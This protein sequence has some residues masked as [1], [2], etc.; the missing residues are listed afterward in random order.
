MFKMTFFVSSTVYQV[1]LWTKY[2]KGTSTS[3]NLSSGSLI[4]AVAVVVP[5]KSA[6]QICVTKKKEKKNDKI[7]WFLTHLQLEH[8]MVF[9]YVFY[10]DVITGEQTL[11]RDQNFTD[12]AF[13]RLTVGHW[14]WPIIATVNTLA[15]SI[16]VAS[17]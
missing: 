11:P 16:T 7:W 17:H 8:G 6:G 2:S 4:S 14:I 5:E 13:L 15:G 1:I 10:I 12:S 9:L 3:D